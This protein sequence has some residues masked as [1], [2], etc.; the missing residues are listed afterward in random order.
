MAILGYGFVNW[1]YG[2]NNFSVNNEGWF[3]Q[4]AAE[5]GSDKTAHAYGAYLTS[6]LSNQL[7][8]KWGYSK[9]EAKKQALLTSIILTT[10]TEIGDGRPLHRSLKFP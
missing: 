5:G 6:R 10:V 9:E 1:D 8:L 4:G 3:S 7:Y 2:T